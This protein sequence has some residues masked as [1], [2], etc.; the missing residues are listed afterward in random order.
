MPDV[1]TAIADI[2]EYRVFT[3]PHAGAGHTNVNGPGMSFEMYCKDRL[4]GLEP[5]DDVNRE[6]MYRQYLAYQGAANNP[7]DAMYRGGDDGDAFEF[8]KSEGSPLGDISLNS[9]WPK[10]RLT[11]GS[12][13]ILEDC[14]DCESWTER[15]LFYVCG[16]VPQGTSRVAWIWICDARLMAAE[17]AVYE[18]LR[19]GI[20]QGIIG[21]PG[22]QFAETTELGKVKHV[23][24]GASTSLR[25][26]GMWSIAKP[27]KLFADLPGVCHSRNA[28]LHALIRRERWLSYPAASRNRLERMRGSGGTTIG[29][30]TVPNP[31]GG[32]PI[33]SML[34]RFEIT[35]T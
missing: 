2:I 4:V 24:P 11:V 33:P 12:H 19:E 25:I 10:D 14:R 8:K 1:L 28:N 7:P 6:Q 29:E 17:A 5:G 23:D 15:N 16:G 3:L 35:P 20:R 18:R 22:V 9:S 34:V 21:I 30:V 31:N 32:A 27:G 13:G 26:R